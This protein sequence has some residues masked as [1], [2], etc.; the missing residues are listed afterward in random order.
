M[1]GRDD[2]LIFHPGSMNCISDLVNALWLFRS[3]YSEFNTGKK[4]LL[5][6]SE[7][8]LHLCT[9]F[10]VGIVWSAE[11]LFAS[12]KLS[13]SAHVR[14][15]SY[16]P[17]RS[18]FRTIHEIIYSFLQLAHSRQG[19]WCTAKQL[20]TL[21]FCPHP[22]AWLPCSFHSLCNYNHI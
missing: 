18:I 6:A 17:W 3:E 13:I 19:W 14:N 7:M 20:Q 4:N 22:A 2:L 12:I 15:R 1:L 21:S 10:Q 8:F 5:S 9:F 11:L 16:Y